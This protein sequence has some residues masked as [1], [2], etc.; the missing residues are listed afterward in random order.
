M[1]HNDGATNAT[2]GNEPVRS[3]RPLRRGC[4][5]RR[6]LRRSFSHSSPVPAGRRHPRF[7]RCIGSH[8]RSSAVKPS[9][10]IP[11]ARRLLRST[12]RRSGRKR[13]LTLHALQDAPAPNAGQVPGVPQRPAS[14]D[15]RFSAPPRLFPA[16][17]LGE[18]MDSGRYNLHSSASTPRTP[19]VPA[20]PRPAAGTA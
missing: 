11:R 13:Q 10:G 16:G 3:L 5:R 9:R 7:V 20:A 8:L 12:A 19:P 18:T 4:S 6:C 14:S 1:I 2:S 17:R 15:L